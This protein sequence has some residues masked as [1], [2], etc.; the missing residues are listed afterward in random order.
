[1]SK[2]S[3]EY[4]YLSNILTHENQHL[5]QERNLTED[6]SCIICHPVI[7]TEITTEFTYFWKR[8]VQPRYK[9]STYSAKT[10]EIF[11]YIRVSIGRTAKLLDQLT[12]LVKTIRYSQIPNFQVIVDNIHFYWSVTEKFNNWTPYYSESSESSIETLSESSETI[13]PDEMSGNNN[14]IFGEEDFAYETTSWKDRANDQ[15]RHKSL[16]MVQD[17]EEG[18]GCSGIGIREDTNSPFY[19]T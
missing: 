17:D 6:P 15:G 13:Q 5:Q 4:Q 3:E 7:E 12:Q 1:M 18:D 11:E 19:G 10:I 8:C 2:G 9:D 14:H 16:T